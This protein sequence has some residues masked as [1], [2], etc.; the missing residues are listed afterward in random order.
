MTPG[1]CKTSLLMQYFTGEF[2]RLK[3][4]YQRE[5]KI[6]VT[7]TVFP[8]IVSALEYTVNKYKE[9]IGMV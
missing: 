4:T 8:S 2:L 3:T 1:P 9:I 7:T 5:A 6:Y